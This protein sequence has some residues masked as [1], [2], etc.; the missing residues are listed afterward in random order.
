MA[1]VLSSLAQTMG[2]FT[3]DAA[4]ALTPAV[5]GA[6]SGPQFNAFNDPAMFALSKAQLAA[7]STAVCAQLATSKETFLAPA[8][9]A[10]LSPRCIDAM[11][12]WAGF[13]EGCVGHWNA[14]AV[15]SGSDAQLQ[16]FSVS[17]W[18]GVNA[19]EFLELVT[20][21]R[22]LM[23]ALTADKL[24]D[25]PDATIGPLSQQLDAKNLT[26]NELCKHTASM[27]TATWLNVALLTDNT[28][29]CLTSAVMVTMPD[30]SL[31]GL[32]KA[33]VAHVPAKAFGNI[34]EAQ[35]ANLLADGVSGLNG[36]DIEQ[37]SPQS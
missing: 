12:S 21:R 20:K 6:L 26:T 17:G 30:R 1:T 15:A 35:A 7:L 14:S 8:A 31:A 25:V 27:A 36:A 13:A 16:S 28:T 37:F 4:A 5:I 33:Q 2:A 3:P 32:R 10:G 11:P 24:A 23:S 34:T 22:A 18:A 19:D 9:C 29:T